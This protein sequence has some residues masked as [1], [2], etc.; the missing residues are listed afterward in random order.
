[1]FPPGFGGNHLLNL[2]GL[3]SG[4]YQA[5]DISHF[6]NNSE[7][8]VHDDVCNLQKQH[9]HDEMK[10]HKDLLLLCGHIGEYLFL[11]NFFSR[12]KNKRFITF[13]WTDADL[14]R[15][16]DRL[17]VL[18]YDMFADG[19]FSNEQRSLY[20]VRTV[21][22]LVG[23]SQQD[24]AVVNLDQFIALDNIELLETITSTM[25]IPMGYNADICAKLHSKWLKSN[26]IAN[27]ANLVEAPV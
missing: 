1:M 27:Q 3:Y 7:I 4:L 18:R 11:D 19:Y 15:L 12:L 23:Q 9:V 20:D 24:I 6:Y 21:S 2:L 14:L 10:K 13:N 17:R 16:N 25:G 26:N 5:N 8:N 22:K